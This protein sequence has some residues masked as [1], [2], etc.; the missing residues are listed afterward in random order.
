MNSARANMRAKNATKC[1]GCN[2]QDAIWILI[3]YDNI[4]L[5]CDSCMNEISS[6]EGEINLDFY[7]IFLGWAPIFEHINKNL[8]YL[9]EQYSSLLKEYSKFKKEAGKSEA[10]EALMRKQPYIN[11]TPR[12]QYSI[13]STSNADR[14]VKEI[15]IILFP[16][17]EDKE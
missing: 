2:D 12:G 8:K 10:I 5:L 14:L 4:Q 9:D 16:D 13:Q 17:E 15:M 3:D 7:S 6:I 1:T 11:V